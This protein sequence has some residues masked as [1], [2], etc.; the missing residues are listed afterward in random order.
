MQTSSISSFDDLADSA[1]IRE[2]QLVR[3]PKRPDR[4][5]LIPFGSSTLWRKVKSGDFPSPIKLSPKVTA[6]KVRDVR[7]WMADLIA[8]PSSTIRSVG[9]AA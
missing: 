2:S 6:W 9:C 5:A 1:Y 3:N 7:A 4:P 8:S